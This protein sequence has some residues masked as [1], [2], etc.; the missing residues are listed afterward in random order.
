MMGYEL[1][2]IGTPVKLDNDD[3]MMTGRIVG[4]S[5][6]KSEGVSREAVGERN[7]DLH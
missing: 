2:Q 4:F 5:T 3:G 6:Y 1:I 7:H